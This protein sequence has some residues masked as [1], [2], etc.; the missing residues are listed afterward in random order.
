MREHPGRVLAIYIR[1]VS[2]GPARRRA[3]E[4]LAVEVVEAGS[5]LLLAADSMAIARHAVEHGLIA[6]RALAEV[7]GE[8]D[9]EGEPACGP[10]REVAAPS[11]SQT[12]QAVQGA[13]ADAL[14]RGDG[15]ACQCQCR[16]P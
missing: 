8:K 4:D 10:T 11:P 7:L 14:E 5:S 13:L 12:E 15:V 6:P 2:R 9:R 16:G 1:N 3:I